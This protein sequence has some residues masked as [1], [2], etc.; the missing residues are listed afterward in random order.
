[1]A[2]LIIL[3]SISLML[4]PSSLLAQSKC[5]KT[6]TRLQARAKSAVA[7]YISSPDPIIRE[8]AQWIQSGGNTP[9]C[10][11]SSKQW[12]KIKS[13]E[14][15]GGL[16]IKYM[17]CKACSCPRDKVMKGWAKKHGLVGL[18]SKFLEHQK[19]SI[20][21][22]DPSVLPANYEQKEDFDDVSYQGDTAI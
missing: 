12:K 2:K 11:S 10:T 3:L 20:Y 18:K 9:R 19:A 8:C 1:M 17:I 15:L 6:L 4:F 21:T 16:Q 13:N 22:S 5:E 14:K 7:K